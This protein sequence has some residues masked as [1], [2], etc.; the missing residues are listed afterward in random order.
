MDLHP[1]ISEYFRQYCAGRTGL[2]FANRKGKPFLK[3]NLLT[4]WLRPRLL[5]LKTYRR[6]WGW[7]SLRRFRSTWLDV[8]RCQ[9]DIK[10]K[11]LGHV[12]RSMSELY[13]SFDSIL[14][15]RLAEAE[16]MGVGFAVPNCPGS[17]P[18][19]ATI[20]DT[21]DVATAVRQ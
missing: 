9:P 4:L 7:H 16:K 2:L 20:L 1:D 15:Q 11:W 12:P 8:Q 3:E 5:P 6:G 14:P 10:N 19:V 21:V 17:M 18:Q 13:F